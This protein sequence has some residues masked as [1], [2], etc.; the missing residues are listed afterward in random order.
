MEPATA[1]ETPHAPGGLGARALRV[2]EV[3]LGALR[4]LAL[5]GI[6]ILGLAGIVGLVSF[7][8]RGTPHIFADFWTAGTYLSFA[9]GAPLAAQTLLDDLRFP[10]L[11]DWWPGGL[12]SRT[13]LQLPSTSLWYLLVDA[14]PIAL[15][16]LLLRDAQMRAPL[17]LLVAVIAVS[18]A[19]SAAVLRVRTHR[20]HGR[21]TRPADERATVDAPLTGGRATLAFVALAALPVG[22]AAGLVLAHASLALWLVAA[23][24]YF[25]A[26]AWLRGVLTAPVATAAGAAA[27]AP[28]SRRRRRR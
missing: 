28:A 22:V 21:T 18:V 27:A 15:T 12:G 8:A 24:A 13:R 4:T 20:R 1:A 19:G 9:L 26:A 5:E 17:G 11:L 25:V 7:V 6:V 3:L 23:T 10:D 2:P 14:L 16:A